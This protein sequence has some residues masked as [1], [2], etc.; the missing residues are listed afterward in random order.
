MAEQEQNDASTREPAPGGPASMAGRDDQD[1]AVRRRAYE[2]SQS[3]DSGTDEENWLR[4]E[5]E[6]RGGS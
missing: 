5:Q 1:E 2:L 6:L 4:A 3:E